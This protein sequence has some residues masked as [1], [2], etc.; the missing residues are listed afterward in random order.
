[1]LAPTG[2]IVADRE[3]KVMKTGE[4]ADFSGV[5]GSDRP[6]RSLDQVVFFIPTLLVALFLLAIVSTL[7]AFSLS[8]S[9]QAWDDVRFFSALKISLASSLLSSILAFTLAVPYA[10]LLSRRIIRGSTFFESVGTFLLG[11]PP[12]GV[13]VALLVFFS[14][15]PL[16]SFIDELL[17]FVFTFKGIVMAQTIVVFPIV[18]KFS[19]EVIDLVPRDLEDVYLVF[20]GTR[21]F[22][23]SRIVLPFCYRGL[24]GSWLVGWMRS[25][26]EF[27]ATLVIAGIVS[28]RTETLT[29]YMYT[30]LAT[31][32]LA[33]AAR[34]LLTLLSMTLVVSLIVTLSFRIK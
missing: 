14:M 3:V 30:L 6:S 31:A 11:L 23:F 17:G 19:K 13:G 16:G 29:S 4:Y 9:S 10:Y 1:M 28:G 32:D 34:V 20:G 25:L 5:K 26:G 33:G 8:T 2:G 12:V 21:L 7:L 15:N 24:L 22:T 27:G 18:V